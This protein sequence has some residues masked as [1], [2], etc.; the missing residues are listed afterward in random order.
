MVYNRERTGFILT[1]VSAF[2]FASK[3]ILAKLAYGYGVDAVT[4]LALRMA[5]AGG[6][7][8]LILAWNL[9]KKN[10][11]I[12]LSGRQ[13][14][15]ALMLGICGYYLSA[16]LDFSGLVYVDASLGR[17]ILFLYP[18]LVLLINS[19]LKHQPVRARTWLALG[20]CYSGIFLMMVQSLGGESSNLLLGSLM[21]FGSAL[22]YACYL[23]GVD[24]L[25]KSIDPMR[26][27][28]LV[29]CISCLSVILHY[30]LTRDLGDLG[31]LP[32]PVF[33]NG[34]L[35][36]VFSTV[37]PIYALT[38]GIAMIGASRAAMISMIGP[39]LTLF[40][41]AALLDERLTVIQFVGMFMVMAGVWRVGK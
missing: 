7:F 39:V 2:A 19:F 36:G 1:L 17:M 24:R 13:W 33:L 6:I 20:L 40:M 8:A 34:A 3:T 41:G 12:K 16:L 10:W 30:L 25:L 35:M 21:I 22:V 27:T 31:A 23:V 4:L 29:M 9:L 26:F 32:A 18:T 15:W 14:L 28:S 5:F 11:T 38:A 37:L